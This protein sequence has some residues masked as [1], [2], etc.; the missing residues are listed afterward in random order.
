[1]STAS[2]RSRDKRLASDP[3]YRERY[4]RQA[5]EYAKRR[6]ERMGIELRAKKFGITE[7]QL[8]SLEAAHR[9]ECAICGN[10]CKSGR[11]LAIDHDHETKKV[12]GLLCGNCNRGIGMFLDNPELMRRAAGYVESRR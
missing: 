9:G 11:R 2:V 6:R 4:L 7:D 5:R 8:A 10:G 1:L 12:R 3:D